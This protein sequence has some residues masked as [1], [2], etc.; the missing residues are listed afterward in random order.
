MHRS[1]ESFM[2]VTEVLL[3]V[4]QHLSYNKSMEFRKRN[5]SAKAKP[6]SI[7]QTAQKLNGLVHRQEL[8]LCIYY[9]Y[10][11]GFH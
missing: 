8:Y 2:H 1:A 3:S 7:S 5:R 6:L 4:S 11:K 10:L 9:I